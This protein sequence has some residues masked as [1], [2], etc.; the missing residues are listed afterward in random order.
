MTKRAR[1]ARART[2]RPAVAGSQLHQHDFPALSDFVKGYLHQDFVEE[3]GSAL[4]AAAAFSRDAS[5]SERRELAA[6][7]AKLVERAHGLPL[8]TLR[9]FV[10][11]EL[12]SGWEPQ[13][14][15]DFTAMLERLRREE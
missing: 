11:R 6:E 13:S 1:P 12:G 9:R 7:L 4:E 15:A 2:A 14:V 5:S 10:T 3:H 8:S